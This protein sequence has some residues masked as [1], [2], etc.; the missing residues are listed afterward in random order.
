M[1]AQQNQTGTSYNWK[2]GQTSIG[3]PGRSNDTCYPG[4]DFMAFGQAK[5]NVNT[6]IVFRAFDDSMMMGINTVTANVV[7][8]SSTVMATASTS[9]SAN[10]TYL[11][12]GFFKVTIPAA[13]ATGTLKYYLKATDGA[14]NIGYQPGPTV[15][16]ATSSAYSL[17]FVAANDW[18]MSVSGTVLDSSS[19]P[20]V[21]ATVVDEGSASST[22]TDALG[23]Y[24]LG[25]LPPSP[26]NLKAFKEGYM[27]MSRP[28]VGANSTGIN[29]TLNS[30]NAGFGGGGDMTKPMVD[31]TGPPDRMTGVASG[32]FNIY[33][34][35]NRPMDSTTITASGAI[36]ATRYPDNTAVAGTV[37]YY[38]SPSGEGM[39][40][41]PNLAV[42]ATSESLGAGKNIV[43]KV[44]N[45]A[46]DTNG[47]TIQGNTTDGSYVFSFNTSADTTGGTYGQGAMVPPYV[48]GTTPGGGTFN[49]ARNTKI[50]I[51][52]SEPMQSATITTANIALY[53]LDSSGIETGSAVSTTVSLDSSA[54]SKIVT[55]TPASNLGDGTNSV[56]YRI[57]IKGAVQSAA[58]VTFS[59]SAQ[60]ANWSFTQDFEVGI[61]T[62]SA[63]PTVLGTYPTNGASNTP[64]NQAAISVSFNKPMSS[65]TINTSNITLKAGTSAVTGTLN[66]NPLSR[67][68]K[69]APATALSANTSYTLTVGTNVQSLTG[70]AIATSTASFTTGSSDSTAPRVAFANADDYSLAVTFSEPMSSAAAADT[71]NYASSTL[72]SARYNVRQGA[73][74]ST[75]DAT[76][77]TVVNVTNAQFTYDAPTMTVTIKGLSLPVGNDFYV[78]VTG[79]KDVSCNQI[80]PAANNSAKGTVLNSSFTQGMLG[81]GGSGTTGTGPMG[82]S[83]MST[84]DT[85]GMMPINVMP[86]TA[87]ASKSSSYI[88]NFPITKALA[89]SSQIVLVFPEGF[90]LANATTSSALEVPMNADVNGPGSGVIRAITTDRDD[91]AHTLTFITYG[92]PT[93][94]AGTS[95]TADDKDFINFQIKNVINASVP[96][97]FGTSG[98]QV[99]I[100]TKNTSGQI[101][102]TMTSMSF[103][104]SSLGTASVSG[105]VLDD[106]G[107]G[108]N[109]VTVFMGSPMTGP[110]STTTATN[111][112]GGGQAGEF[113]FTQL[114]AGNLFL[115]TPP[116]VT[117]AAGNEYIGKPSTS[118]IY[119]T[120]TPIINQ[121]ITI[122]TSAN[123]P[124]IK[125]KIFGVPVGEKIDIYASG[126]NGGYSVKS[127]RIAAASGNNLQAI[128]SETGADLLDAVTNVYTLRAPATST[129]AQRFFVGMN[130]WMPKG[131]QMTGPMPEPNFQPPAPYEISLTYASS[132][133]VFA[134]ST[135][136]VLTTSSSTI[137]VGSVLITDSYGMSTANGLGFSVTAATSEIR[138][139]VVDGSNNGIA[140]ANVHAYQPGGMGMGLHAMTDSAGNFTLKATP[141]IFTVGA[142]APGMPPVAEQNVDVK[143]NNS[144]D[145]GATDSNTTA[146]VIKD[147]VLITATNQLVFKL[148][149]P[150]QVISGRV[151]D[152]IS[153]ISNASVWAHQTNGPGWANAMTDSSGNYTLYVSAG[154]WIV[155]ANAPAV[156]YLG[157]LTVTV[158]SGANQTNQNFQ[159]SS[160]LGTITGTVYKDNDSTGA[161]SAG[162]E[163]ITNAFVGLER[164]DASGGNGSPVNGSGV[165]SIRVP[166]GTYTVHAFAP[167]FGEL[168]T[169]TGQ[170]LSAGTPSITLNFALTA[171][172]A[173]T[174]KFWTGTTGSYTAYTV[175]QGFVDAQTANNHSGT[176]IT[177]TS[178][179]II[180][181]PSGTYVMHGFIDGQPDPQLSFRAD[182]S[183]QPGAALTGNQI[184]ATSNVTVHLVVASNMRTIAGRVWKDET[185]GTA[186]VY[187]NGTDTPLQYA[188]VWLATTDKVFGY[189]GQTDSNGQYTLKAPDGTYKFGCDKPGYL[190]SSPAD[191]TVS[192]NLADQNFVMS[193][194][195][196][197]KITGTVYAGGSAVANAWVWAKR[198]GGGWAGSNTDANG[199][200][201]LSV[202]AGIW[203]VEAAYEGYETS[204]ANKKLITV[205]TSN[206]S[207]TNITLTAIS[208]YTTGLRM[209]EP[210][211][212]ANGGTVRGS[213]SGGRAFS[214][215]VPP[216]ALGTDTNS[217]SL[218]VTETSNLPKIDSMKIVG[219]K[220]V[221]V[222]ATNSSNQSL[223]NLNS[224]IEINLTYT[225]AELQDASLAFSDITN[226]KLGYWDSTLSN[227]VTIPTVVTLN[228]TTATSYANLTDVTLKGTMDHL[229]TIAPVV[230]QGLGAPTT[231]T[232][233]AGSGQTTGS[234]YLH[235]TAS[236]GAT[237]YN[238]YRDTSTSGTFPRVGS[239]GLTAN[240][241]YTDSGL[242]PST[243]YYYKVSAKNA[244][245]ES[246]A[247]DYASVST[248]SQ[249][250]VQ[251]SVGGS[252]GPVT[253]VASPSPSPTVSPSP[254]PSVSPSPTASPIAQAP[255]KISPASGSTPGSGITGIAEGALIK[256]ANDAKVYIVKGGYARWIQNPDIFK[257]YKHFK[258]GDIKTVSS[259][260]LTKYTEASLVRASGDKKVYEINGDGTK[261][262]LNMTAEQF[263]KSGRR[264]DMVYVVNSAEVKLYKTGS[265]V[266]YSSKA[267]VSGLVDKGKIALRN[268][269]DWMGLL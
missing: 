30:E 7:Y 61:N 265:T 175:T 6:D 199:Y 216:N 132:T 85:M 261:H 197:R 88:I 201:E 18:L 148:S 243:T 196:D 114:S 59:P 115:G 65:G 118:M 1:T 117:D 12:A 160:T 153:G 214:A 54:T 51:V 45:T 126:F 50:E 31:M 257:I 192:G 163:L 156:G 233:L 223:T 125:G 164:T 239:E 191:L 83:G 8:S 109:G 195:G 202:T 43:V 19:N 208:G 254:S 64:V 74:G 73:A 183:G 189:G 219:S 162:D 14:G 52:F 107:N 121:N 95:D 75:V 157:S 97:E 49:N 212:P 182:S 116:M 86:M 190:G 266:L 169:Q 242:E 35:F 226:L 248:Q 221:E 28:G 240:T 220:G 134:S 252:A 249:S 209:T 256:A 176:S 144:V 80:D 120:T 145:T 21:G 81:P 150:A 241:Y 122:S 253:L 207:A 13:A 161:Y 105:R 225:A 108:V 20:I 179:A 17:S 27:D 205:S 222:S 236:D 106:L 4:I 23:A 38:A 15:A 186:N 124:P 245:G 127:Y 184:A 258:W 230:A 58:G 104:I 91:V 172:K 210:I 57:K 79:V 260:D 46:A 227:W 16:I 235:W 40:T 246:A 55:V 264:W 168:P 102:E 44:A 90:I 89:S 129:A 3:T 111:M 42:F 11:G 10:G 70:V 99:T 215:V 224:S 188:W 128:N 76:N 131:P 135:I 206:V 113:T 103:F 173:I 62:D 56:K 66:Y 229:T 32:V 139:K 110:M 67:E 138:G 268:L 123:L 159:I 140:N 71:A 25:N 96:R 211:T 244:T 39:P 63:A 84:I 143:A 247:S 5:Q 130:L 171:P 133:S 259:S 147:G 152:G 170:T 119:A 142:Y 204:A 203:G 137:A 149:K 136:T 177:G 165:Y 146:D 87:V 193:S 232:G 93:N 94:G 178:S 69:F 68:A 101:L 151:S 269:L 47:N 53:Q 231:P 158:T 174:V 92:A 234:I 198:T 78:G 167:G 33:V 34:G 155:E 37:S 180:Y 228:P 213:T 218:A 200:Y 48:T 29:F 36:S 154:T 72:N 60:T 194:S 237:Y 250:T 9:I 187:D 77:G 181:V 217:G 26:H 22:V 251:T 112:A 24:S 166:Y 41:H 267:V 238:L 263:T 262:W 141:G 2:A 100:K 185:G 98:Y 82:P 255:T